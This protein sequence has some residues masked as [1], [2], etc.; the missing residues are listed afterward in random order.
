MGFTGKLAEAAFNVLYADTKRRTWSTPLLLRVGRYVQNIDIV[1][2]LI[3]ALDIVFFQ[4]VS[5]GD[6]WFLDILS[7]FFRRFNVNLKTNNYMSKIE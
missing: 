7:Y 2:I 4:Y 1:S 6:K 5:I 3:G